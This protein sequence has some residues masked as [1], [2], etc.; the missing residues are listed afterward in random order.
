MIPSRPHNSALKHATRDTHISLAQALQ[1]S[2]HSAFGGSG[3]SRNPHY[4]SQQQQ[5]H[6]IP[7]N[8]DQPFDTLYFGPS[9]LL[10]LCVTGPRLLLMMMVMMVMMMMVVLV[11]LQL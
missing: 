8:S 11:L 9:P 4:N 1:F 10:S 6:L 5:A 7:L 2:N 3:G